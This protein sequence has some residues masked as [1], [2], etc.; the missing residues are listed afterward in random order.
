MSATRTPLQQVLLDILE[1]QCY[2]LKNDDMGAVEVAM[3]DNKENP[4]T[5]PAKPNDDVALLVPVN[6]ATE[7]PAREEK[8]SYAVAASSSATETSSKT[9]ETSGECTNCAKRS[10]PKGASLFKVHSAVT[11]QPGRVKLTKAVASLQWPHENS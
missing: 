6:A 2:P 7:S 9:Q 5:S 11:K 4:A 3:A 8:V 10:T 1:Q